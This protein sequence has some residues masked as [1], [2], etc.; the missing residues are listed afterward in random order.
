MPTLFAVDGH[1]LEGMFQ[2]AGQKQE[3][4]FIL[5]VF[6]PFYIG[7][8]AQFFLQCFFQSCLPCTF[9]SVMALPSVQFNE[10]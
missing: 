3:L 9:S 2:D 1:P 4:P 6:S 8:G 7:V 10:L 5:T